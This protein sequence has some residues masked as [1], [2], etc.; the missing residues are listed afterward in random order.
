MTA[1]LDQ[2]KDK[3][4]E[5]LAQAQ[6]EVGDFL[7]QK[8]RILAAPKTLT[9]QQLLNANAVLQTRATAMI[10]EASTVKTRLDAFNPMKFSE[11]GKIGELTKDAGVL[12]SNLL[13]LREEM[14]A[15]VTQVDQLS[16]APQA[17]PASASASWVA[18]LG[19]GL[20]AKAAGLGF[21]VAAG[22]AAYR[23]Y[24]KRKGAN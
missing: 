9:Q 24:R 21:L 15:H 8:K 2:F 10:A 11:Y 20:G 14:K 5:S 22:V 4:D 12:A 1:L 16:S 18:H 17:S 3:L 6:D 7:K 19:N 23:E 13:K